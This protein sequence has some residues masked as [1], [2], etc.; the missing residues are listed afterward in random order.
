MTWRAEVGSAVLRVRGLKHAFPGAGD[1]FDGLSFTATSGELIAIV[2]P[3]GSGK[4]TLLHLI[5]GWEDPVG[6]SVE[7]VGVESIG[8]VFQNPHG[9]PGRT[10]LD[11]VSLP[12]LARG[13]TR[14]DAEGIASAALRRFN[15]DGLA[16]R[17]FRHLSGGE[18]Q[19]LML[20]R[21]YVRTPGLLLVD[22]PTAQLDPSTA[23]S[24]NAVLAEIAAQDSIVL[25]ATHDPDTRDACARI[26][27]LARGPGARTP[28]DSDSRS[29]RMGG[30]RDAV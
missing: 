15:L 30:M 3:S 22:E 19:R 27:D 13:R 24:V 17:E 18:A 21:A 16:T 23:R 5:A 26:I 9:V 8:W 6:G 10:A 14:H 12:I 25:V 11:H 7:T 20:A 2:G 4:S 29:D 28:G 1:L